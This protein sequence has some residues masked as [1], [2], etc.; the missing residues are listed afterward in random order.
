MG[1]LRAPPQGLL[2][3]W[4]VGRSGT[5]PP[6]PVGVAGGKVES[7]VTSGCRGIYKMRD[8]F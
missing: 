2:E 4:Q 8:G 1:R 7:A 6:G 3:E 5:P